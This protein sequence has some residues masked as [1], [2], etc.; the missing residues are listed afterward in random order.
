VTAPANLGAL[1][2]RWL[3]AWP[4]AL[5][6]W[7]KYTRL[8]EPRWC[9]SAEDEGREGL[10]GSFA[11]IRLTDHAVV[12][13]LRMVE[14]MKLGGFA[15]EVL[16]HEIGHHVLAPGDLADHGRTLARMRAAL[17]EKKEHAPLVANLYTD[18]LIND[19]LR[20]V[21]NLAMVEI[22]LRLAPP[23]PTRL[24]RLY[25]RID[26]ILWNLPRGTL[27]PSPLGPAAEGDAGLGARIVRVYGR[28]WLDGAGRFAALC[29]PYLLKDEIEALA[30][31]VNPWLDTAQAGAGGDPSGLTEI[32]EGEDEVIHPSQDPEI[33]GFD[34]EEDESSAARHPS[35]R[36]RSKKG[37]GAPK[38]R[39]REPAEFGELLRTLGVSL[40]PEEVTIRYY[41][42]RALP[43]LV[44]FPEKPA[45]ASVEP[46]P[47][48]TESW[49]AG[50]PLEDIDWFESVVASPHVIPGVT[51][52]Q[53]TYGESPGASPA[54]TPLDLY[55][56]IDCSGSM[57]NPEHQLSYPVL[58]GT[59]VCLSALRAGAR[60]LSVLSGDPGRH[61][62]SGWFGRDERKILGVLTGYLGTGYAFGIRL[63]AETFDHLSARDRPVHI[64]IVTDHDIF[65]QLEEG[66]GEKN[67]WTV[68]AK[69]LT[70]ARGGGTFVLNMPLDW[71]K[72]KVRRLVE[73]GWNVHGVTN[74]EEIVAFARAFS[75]LKYG[76]RGGPR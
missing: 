29:L 8:A 76:D 9:L 68:A 20:R 57:A 44:P 31:D 28:D 42:E 23:A 72:K 51:T 48:G 75:R 21:H 34:G 38:R 40:S 13:S 63:L 47:E 61:T 66:A 26:E 43:H 67:G 15:R 4:A 33:T 46:L 6:C 45:P 11:M 50:M 30:H 16:A 73:M 7:S 70:A 2:D 27:V 17:A 10:T 5:A 52:V 36:G 25:M 1:R 74:W 54:P 19:R 71:E 39:Y 69:A 62:D 12:I 65:M 41:R 60:C 3:A 37:D 59:I 55:I 18:L 32:E 58:A 24:W 53:R 64:L 35:G 22:Y 56:G 49:E 14:A